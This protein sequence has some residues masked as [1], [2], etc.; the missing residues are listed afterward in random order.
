[1]SGPGRLWKE[2]LSALSGGE[3][4]TRLT[5]EVLHRL[6]QHLK[7]LRGLG[8]VTVIKT[9]ELDGCCAGSTGAPE[10]MIKE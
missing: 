4:G 2:Q 10:K 6:V 5:R 9:V 7:L 3:D 8:Q 1:M